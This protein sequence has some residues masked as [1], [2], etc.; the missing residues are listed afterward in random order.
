MK[1]YK[2]AYRRYKQQVKF[3]RRIEIY[4]C[5]WWAPISSKEDFKQKIRKGDY[6]TFLRTTLNPCNC[7]CCS[8]V[9]KYKRYEQKKLDR[10]EIDNQ[11]ISE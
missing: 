5:T 2:R 3:E 7:F 1:N 11:L 8:E 9:N 6:G 4:V 10:I